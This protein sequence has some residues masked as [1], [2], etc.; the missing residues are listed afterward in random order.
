MVK[1]MSQCPPFEL[2][3]L[4]ETG[5]FSD[6]DYYFAKS[7]AN[8]YGETNELVIA[9]CALVSKAVGHG[10]ICLDLKG[11]LSGGHALSRHKEQKIDFPGFTEWES[12]LN[13]SPMVSNG[14]ET[15]IVIDS[16]HLVYM[17]R[18]YDYQYR[19]ARN[20]VNR[21]LMDEQPYDDVYLNDLIESYLPGE[22]SHI[23][24][25][26]NAV[27]HA[28]SHPFT[29]ISGG[30]GT[31][32]TFVTSVIKNI[33]TSHA[34]KQNRTKPR[35]ITLAP[36][37]K[38]A[39]KLD[40]GSTIHS[41][42]KPLKNRPGFHHNKDN[43]IIADVVIV[44]ESSMVDIALFTILMEA[45]PDKAKVILLGDKNQLSSVQ[46][47]SV[48]NDLCMVESLSE[49]IY[50]FE[51]NFRSKGKTG[52]EKFSNA[53][54]NNNAIEI[55]DILGSN[56]YQD[57]V[58]LNSE[59]QGFQEILA[60]T[61]KKEYNPF[62]ASHN[63]EAA[64]LHIDDFKVLCAVNSGSYG[65][66]SISYLCENILRS[67]KNSGIPG[68][69]FYHM[70]MVNTNDYKKG[71]FNGDT[72][73]II[74]TDE[75]DMAY[76]KG[77]ENNIR[78]FSPVDLPGY[79]NAFAI[80]IHKSQGSEFN[81]VL[82][83]VPEIISPVLTRQLLYTGVTRA[84]EKVIIAGKIDIIKQAAG[85]DITRTSGLTDCLEKELNNN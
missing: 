65:T 6:L 36:T 30:P 14:I 78:E 23:I 5:F 10:H 8:I 64:L 83:I 2:E 59:E 47:G 41:L 46:A 71:L 42:L 63:L 58:F 28:V 17:S 70:I 74:R 51:F 76:F 49:C 12:A 35:I 7:M 81:K 85:L 54:K 80:T 16:A 26:K 48:F 20:I 34:D 62:T 57:I 44:D 19:F 29:I 45:I 21:L 38:A 11:I 84:K 55:E 77:S 1:M 52:I 27:K 60:D 33:I 32:K 66:L 53:V 56:K 61:I 75:E 72:G 24:Y 43:Q 82:I 73:I 18:Y 37:G 67:D 9:A 25:Q 69:L 13:S 79:D 22:K 31:G 40:Q 39:S 3:V 50:N 68:A 4:Y 15:P